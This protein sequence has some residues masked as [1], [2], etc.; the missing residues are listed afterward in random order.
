MYLS[1][2]KLNKINKKHAKLI[3]G[4]MTTALSNGFHEKA[5]ERPPP[6]NELAM[7]MWDSDVD[8]ERDQLLDM[9]AM[10]RNQERKELSME[11]VMRSAD[12]QHNAVLQ[13][14]WYVSE[15]SNRDEV[16]AQYILQN[17]D[18]MIEYKGAGS[19][20]RLST[21]PRATH[22]NSSNDKPHDN[23]NVYR[24]GDYARLDEGTDRGP[25]PQA[26]F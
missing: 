9:L 16:L 13:K 1:G 22:R 17:I 3:K 5:E 7:D 2:E 12:A 10:E 4:Y 19:L 24:V 11:D 18:E 14:P 8:E 23:R 26:T 20:Q 6:E 21:A 15:K 25:C